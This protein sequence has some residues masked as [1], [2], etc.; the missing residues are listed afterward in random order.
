LPRRPLDL[1]GADRWN[2]SLPAALLEGAG[3][4]PLISLPATPSPAVNDTAAGGVGVA[5]AICCLP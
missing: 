5:Q 2:G 1:G 3:A 4:T